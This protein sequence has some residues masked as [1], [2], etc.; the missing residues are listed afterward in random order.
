M[1]NLTSSIKRGVSL[2]SYQEEYFLRKLTLE[3]CMA[4]SAGFGAKG[5]EIISEQMLPGF[6]NYSDE[7]YAKW[8]ELLAKYGATPVC[9]DM[10]LDTKLYKHR[11]LTEQEMVDSVTIDIQHASRL[12]CKVIRMIVNT[13]PSVMEKCAPIAEQYG[14]KLC[15]E[16]HSPF[17]FDHEWI[18]QHLEVMQK[19]GSPYLGIIPDMGIFVKRY[20]RVMSERYV[21]KGAQE[22][23]VRYMCEAYEH[24]ADRRQLIEDVKKMGGNV[25]DLN[26]AESM[27]HIIY[28]NPR[29]LLEFMPYIHHIHAKFYDMLED[30]TEYSI[31]YHEIIPVLE[32]GGYNG[33]LSSEYEG[34]RH[35][36]DAFEVNSV[37]QVRRQQMMFKRLLGENE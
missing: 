26:M 36:Q 31:P 30:Y 1:T 22:H 15:L 6:P 19:T 20:P 25:Q 35:I 21:R 17:G 13:P 4:A 12:G 3:D 28:E 34:N 9:H 2:Y 14:V 33:Y 8:H 11:L 7:F 16:I 10:F 24:N 18:V 37:E 5:I 27:V 29:R 32:E 23:V